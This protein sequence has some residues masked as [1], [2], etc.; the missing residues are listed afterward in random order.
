MEALKLVAR[1]REKTGRNRSGRERRLG[2]VPGVV[3]GESGPLPL[4]FDGRE[5]RSVLR[6]VMGRAAIVTLELES[7]Q[8]HAV[9][10]DH[11]RHPIR[12]TLLHVDFHEVSLEK[13]MHAHVPIRTVGV[14]ECEGVKQENGILEFVTH[15][16]EVRCLPADLPSECT[17]DVTTLRLRQ[18]ITVADLVPPSGVEFISHADLV[19]VACAAAQ[20]KQ[21]ETE[22]AASGEAKV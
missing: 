21:E 11:Q 13:K 12:D 8:R 16:V 3:Y 9:V 20:D 19:I 4:V 10:A 17:V 6:R 22:T 7:G 1:R 15:V 2:F 18:K 5:L 14:D